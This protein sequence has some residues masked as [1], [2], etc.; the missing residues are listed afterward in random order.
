MQPILAGARRERGQTLLIFVLA[1]SVLLGFTAMAIDVGLFFEDRR[2]YQNTADAAALAG[3]AE[4][5]K[6]PAAAKQKAA[7]WIANNGVPSS[8]IISIEVRSTDYTNDTVFVELQGDFGWIFGRVLGKTTDKVGAS[9]AAQ[10]GSLSGNNDL[11]PWSIVYGDSLC[12]DVNNDPIPGATCSVKVGAGSGTTGWYGALDLDGTGGGSAEYESNIVDGTA[13]TVYCSVGQTEPECETTDIDALDGNKVGGTGHGIDER[14]LA[15]ATAGCSLDGDD[16]DDFNEVFTPN[17]S[18]VA[19]Y[20]VTC[21]DSP[22]L[23]IVPIVT[24][25]GDPVKTVTLQGWALA[26]LESYSCVGAAQC[27][28]AK[29][30]WEVQITM[31]DAVYSQAAGFMGAFDPSASIIV[32]R[33]IE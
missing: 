11:M 23:I 12:L 27:T 20:T 19:D 33:L 5:P 26:Y 14:L 9:A 16:V 4:L 15:E 1:I 8:E 13:D 22:R 30:H 7:D 18:G 25:N 17:T 24:L 10:V 2:H 21:P 32:R 28:G 6:D 29:G 3:V 31:V